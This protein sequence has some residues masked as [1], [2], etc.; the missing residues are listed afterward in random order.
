LEELSIYFGKTLH[1]MKWTTAVTS[2]IAVNGLSGYW[3][4]G[5][6]WGRALRLYYPDLGDS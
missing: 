3:R 5:V 1:K 6:I 4:E 2:T